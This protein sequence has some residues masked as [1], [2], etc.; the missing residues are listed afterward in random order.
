MPSISTKVRIHASPR[1][2][3]DVL[4]DFEKYPEWNPFVIEISGEKQGIHPQKPR[5]S[6]L[7]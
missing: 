7:S 6:D 1:R 2:V 4:M 5:A 3:W